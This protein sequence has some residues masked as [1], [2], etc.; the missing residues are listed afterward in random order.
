MCS[1]N[2]AIEIL[3]EACERCKTV[4]GELKSAYLYGSYA[5]GDYH[6]E[7]DVDILLTVDK[8]QEQISRCRMA[9]AEIASD[10]SLEYDVTVS[11][12]VKSA[13]LFERYQNVL[14][15]YQNVIKEGVEYAG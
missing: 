5:R 4:F 10:L 8:S 13:E 7:S 6:S 1:K 11:M 15:F 9:V 2:E 12:S 3:N 14:P